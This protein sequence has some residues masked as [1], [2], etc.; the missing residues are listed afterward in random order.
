MFWLFC[1]HKMKIC[2]SGRG[3]IRLAGGWRPSAPSFKSKP[4]AFSFFEKETDCIFFFFYPCVYTMNMHYIF[5]LFPTVALQMPQVLVCFFFPQESQ[6]SCHHWAANSN[7]SSA[8]TGTQQRWSDPGCWVFST[9]RSILFHSFE[10][11]ATNISS[12][13]GFVLSVNLSIYESIPLANDILFS[14]PI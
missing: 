6:H 2:P 9:D 1:S 3:V 5:K 7:Q 13:S 10:W 11:T 12:H 4:L 14:P 8:Q